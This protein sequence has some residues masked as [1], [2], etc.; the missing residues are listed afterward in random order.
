M[1]VR[2]H[3]RMALT[4]PGPK[5]L[6]AMAILF[7]IVIWAVMGGTAMLWWLPERMGDKNTIPWEQAALFYAGLWVWV[8]NHWPRVGTK[9]FFRDTPFLRTKFGLLALITAGFL[10]GFASAA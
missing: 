7:E 10:C 1:N 6:A 4:E 8:L 3:D 9:R 2:L 5:Q